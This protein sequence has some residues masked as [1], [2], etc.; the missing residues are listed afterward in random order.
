MVHSGIIKKGVHEWVGEEEEIDCV[1]KG[2]KG[3]LC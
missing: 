3:R 2:I 1:P